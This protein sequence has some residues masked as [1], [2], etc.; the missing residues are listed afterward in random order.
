VCCLGAGLL[1][2]GARNAARA[3]ATA[4]AGLDFGEPTLESEPTLENQPTAEPTT[5]PTSESE[6]VDL[7]DISLDRAKEQVDQHPRDARARFI[8][9][10]A[11]I[12]D[13]QDLAGYEEIKRGTNLASKNQLLLVS[14]ARSYEKQEI[15]LGAALIYTHLAGSLRAMPVGLHDDMNRAIY[16]GFEEPDAPQVL[17]YDTLNQIDHSLVL[18]AQARHILING[19]DDQTVLDLLD[20]LDAEKPDL[21]ETQLMRAELDIGANDSEAKHILQGLIDAP[22]TPDWIKEEANSLLSEIK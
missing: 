3:T 11:L 22:E 9:A 8:Y 2:Q 10:F 17:S 15:W 1:F 7:S 18:L 5:E 13:G 12:E 14:A 19:N 21:K 16:Y 6:T 4:H 20:Q